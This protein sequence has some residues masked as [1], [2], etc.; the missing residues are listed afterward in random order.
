MACCPDISW[1]ENEFNL[2][3]VSERVNGY[4]RAI[5][6]RRV[7]SDGS[8]ASPEFSVQTNPA[9]D[10]RLPQV[11]RVGSTVVVA[12]SEFDA[13]LTSNALEGVWIDYQGA[14]LVPKTEL[15]PPRGGTW[16][17]HLDATPYGDQVH[18][19]FNPMQPVQPREQVA[20]DLAGNVVLGPIQIG[21]GSGLGLGYHSTI[22]VP[23]GFCTM[24]GMN[25]SGSNSQFFLRRT[26]RDGTFGSASLQV[27]D[28]P[29]GR[30][31]DRET[32]DYSDRIYGVAWTDNREALTQ[33]DV[34]FDYGPGYEVLA[35]GA[36]PAP[37][38]APQVDLLQP[39]D[40]T[41]PV[42]TSLAPYAAGG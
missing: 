32:V 29:S 39:E 42:V 22:G 27:S 2:V 14:I 30:G 7:A 31:V 3:Y 15:V 35:V 8:L 4:S 1:A 20:V 17:S 24:T 34:F 37:T 11:A 12:W 16:F 23:G 18:I 21:E 41:G 5:S 6:Y 13:S 26:S 19:F 33:S 36:G 28:V 38:A 10:I 40:P 25:T 9:G